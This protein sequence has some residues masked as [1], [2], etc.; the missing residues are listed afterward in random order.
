[1]NFADC[2]KETTTATSAATIPLSGAVASFQAFTAAFAVGATGIPVRMEDETGAFWEN[3]FCTFTN[4]TTLTRTEIVSS[5]NGGAPVTFP[6]GTKQVFVT[7]HEGVMEHI[8]RDD[9][10]SLADLGDPATV[11]LFVK[12]A[13]GIRLIPLTAAGITGLQ[14]TTA[15]TLAADDYVPFT[16][17]NGADGR[18]AFANLQAQLAGSAPPADTV[19]PTFSSA[20]VANGAPAVIVMTFNETLGAFTP[21]A[22]AFTVSGGK[23][24]NSVSRSGATVSLTVDSA[25]VNGDVI[26]VQYA[27]PGSNMLQD[28]SGNQ[29]ASFGPSSVTNNILAANTPAS[30]V[31]MTGPSGGTVS[32]ASTNF[33]VGV[34]PVGGTITGTVVV[35]PSDNGGGGSF[36]PATISLT[37][38][39]PTATFTYTPS[40]TAGARTISVTNNGGLS[41][42]S[43]ITYT[44][45]PAEPVGNFK[46]VTSRIGLTESGTGPYTYSGIDSGTFGNQQAVCDASLQTGVDGYLAVRM[47]QLTSNNII[48]GLQTSATYTGFANISIY[49]WQSSGKWAGAGGGTAGATV[50]PATGDIVRLRRAGSSVYAEVARAATPTDF[51]IVHT[52]ASVVDANKYFG[53]NMVSDAK[54]TPV[55]S[56]GLT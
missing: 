25:Y 52:W 27:K 17:A 11:S 44:S 38:A 47:E 45:T 36:N 18:I 5:S 28:A 29:V 19:A 56:S 1:M 14:L 48:F 24:V 41:N 26:T 23:T 30:G 42:P 8:V 10:A 51:T 55:D 7:F 50:A 46:R 15:P 31:T 35:T 22:S 39:S 21:A 20:Q 32:V 9:A 40:S 54:F 37:T 3:I 6:G 13:A 43:N 33:S 34:T 2:V 53:F 12:T 4:A 16:K 49:V